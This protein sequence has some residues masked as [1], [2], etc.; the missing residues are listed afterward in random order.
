[1]KKPE[2]IKGLVIFILLCIPFPDFDYAS[3]FLNFSIFR[4]HNFHFC[5]HIVCFGYQTGA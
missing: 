3:P 1:M 2:I 5:P 4:R